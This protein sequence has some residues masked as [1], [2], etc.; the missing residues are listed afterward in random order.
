MLKSQDLLV[1]LKILSY[2]DSS[3]SDHDLTMKLQG[4]A[5][6][7]LSESPADVNRF[8]RENDKLLISE[9]LSDF[10]KTD[11]QAI[12]EFL[13]KTDPGTTSWTYR[14]LSKQLFMSLGEANKAVKRAVS[15]GLLIERG[16]KPIKVNR[17]RLVEFIRYGA[18]V[19]F[20]AERGK[21]ARGIPTSHAS[22]VFKGVFASSSEQPPVWPCARGTVRGIAI[23]PLY[24][25]VTK[26]VMA[27]SW[28]YQQ[29]AL[30]DIFRIGTVREKEAS[31]KF[32]DQLG[33][34]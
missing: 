26:A 19:A 4:E 12:D 8:D 17:P 7:K 21:V 2:E 31:M 32:L 22:P 27:D 5:W 11:L 30:V 25:S 20:F 14:M 9:E 10:D 24:K 16:T 6:L 23:Q 15:A 33:G 13:S 34:Y 29:L 18:G 3:W 1:V 28:L